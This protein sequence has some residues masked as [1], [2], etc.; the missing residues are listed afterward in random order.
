MPRKIVPATHR[1]GY[2]FL[3]EDDVSA[4]NSGIGMGVGIGLTSTVDCVLDFHTMTRT[5]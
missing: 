2:H 3:D 1:Y 4:G 5:K